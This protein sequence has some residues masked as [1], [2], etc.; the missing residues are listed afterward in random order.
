MTEIRKSNL[1]RFSE[2]NFLNICLQVLKKKNNINKYLEVIRQK[3][4][5]KIAKNTFL[6]L[7]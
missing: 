4:K 5:K 3:E 2:N 7:I 1:G 6:K